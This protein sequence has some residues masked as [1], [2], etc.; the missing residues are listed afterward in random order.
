MET[1]EITNAVVTIIMA[2][3][4]ASTLLF[5]IILWIYYLISKKLMN[6]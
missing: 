3:F 6:K 4:G 2:Y 1:Q 5:G